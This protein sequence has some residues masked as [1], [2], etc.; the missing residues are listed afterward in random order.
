MERTPYAP[1]NFNKYTAVEKV[2]LIKYEYCEENI[3][4]TGNPNH[5]LFCSTG[6]IEQML[7]NMYV[8]CTGCPNR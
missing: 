7:G 8:H 6:I 5:G 1:T 2:N 4:E 3:V